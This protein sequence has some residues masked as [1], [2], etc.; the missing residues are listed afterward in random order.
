MAAEI[1]PATRNDKF[2]ANKK[3]ELLQKL[4]GEEH[5]KKFHITCYSLINQFNTVYRL[6]GRC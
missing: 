4:E 5:V 1:K 6:P 2:N 3:A